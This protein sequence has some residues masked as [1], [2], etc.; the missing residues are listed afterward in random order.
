[1]VRIAYDL[2]YHTCNHRVVMQSKYHG[3]VMHVIRDASFCTSRPITDTASY[4]CWQSNRLAEP[5]SLLACSW[6]AQT[7]Q[8]KNPYL[9]D[10]PC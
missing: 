5:L 4:C 3:V 6:Q 7:Q 9:I 8:L 2:K 10:D 1:M